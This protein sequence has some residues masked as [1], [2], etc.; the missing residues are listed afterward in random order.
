M[1]NCQKFE[2]IFSSQNK[3]SKTKLKHKKTWTGCK[4]CAEFTFPHWK[5]EEQP[6]R[7]P[8]K[9]GDKSAVAVV[10]SVRQLGCVSQDAKP[11]K[12]ATISWK[13]TKVSGPNRQVRFTRAALRQA[14][15]RKSKGPSLSFTSQKFSSAQSLRRKFED[16]SQEETERQERLARG[17]A[18]KLAKNVYKPEETEIKHILFAFR[19]E[20]F[21]W[22][23]PQ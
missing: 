12:S 14:N 5:V 21:C 4:L 16:R 2:R 10:K 1:P 9:G 23:H 6:N 11:P 7:R 22:P 20:W 15:I 8:K 3:K 19:C 17:D 13:S 18:W